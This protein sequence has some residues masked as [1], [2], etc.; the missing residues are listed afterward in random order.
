MDENATAT[1]GGIQVTSDYDQFVIMEANREQNRGHIE[2]IKAAFGE[3]GNLT[4]VQP[5]LVNERFEIID[6]QHR[7]IACK[8]LGE[9][10]LLHPGPRTWHWRR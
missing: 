1:Q 10:S 3:M 7:F 2:A 9:P 5:I 6:G 8:E 4:R